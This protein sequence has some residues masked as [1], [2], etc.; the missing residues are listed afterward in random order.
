VI[1]DCAKTTE[2][3][4]PKNSL[5]TVE[6]QREAHE[7][8]TRTK[9]NRLNALRPVNERWVGVVVFNTTKSCTSRA[10]TK[11]LPLQL[12]YTLPHIPWWALKSPQR[13]TLAT[14]DKK[15]KKAGVKG[16]EGFV[17]VKNEKP[18]TAMPRTSRLL[19]PG[20]ATSIFEIP[21]DVLTQTIGPPPFPL[22]GGR[23]LRIT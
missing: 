20:R 6:V 7:L 21:K 3:S 4:L 19:L 13:I 2:W 14:L 18:C 8:E 12:V 16:S 15:S 5:A 22:E 10:S 9:S 11:D 17:N 23:P 1:A